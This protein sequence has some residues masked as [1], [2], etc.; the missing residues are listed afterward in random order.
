MY[1]GAGN[2]VFLGEHGGDSILGGDGIDTISYAEASA[3][4]TVSLVDGLASG[5]DGE[6]VFD[7]IENIIGSSNNDTLVGDEN[8]N[9]L[10]GGHGSDT[11]TG[12]TGADFFNYSTLCEAGDT[13]TDFMSGTDKFMFLN[14]DN[15]G[16]FA[17]DPEHIMEQTQL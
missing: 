17:V 1:G 6:D 5:S 10:T 8:S 12:G 3:A 9:T 13:I 7:S 11:L 15:D 4:I 2:D 16:D 14:T